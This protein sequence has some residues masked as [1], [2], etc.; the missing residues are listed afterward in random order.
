VAEAFLWGAA[1]SSALLAGA[2]VAYAFRPGPRLNAVVLALG[3]GLLLGAVSL[4]LVEDAIEEGDLL[5]VAL[6]LML[7]AV[8][9]VAGDWVLD[10]RGAAGRKDPR[11]AQAEGS[12][13]GIVLGSVLD[14]IPESLVLGLTVLQGGVGLPLL[15]GVALSNFPEGMASSSGLRAAGWRRRTVLTMWA[16]VAVISACAALAGYVLLEGA[17]GNV[18]AGVNAFAAGALLAMIADTMLP[19]AYEEERSLTGLFVA[20]GFALSVGLDAL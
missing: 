10:R 19:E 4:S 15:M 3:A 16:G 12:A 18:V 6:A 7:G 13:E 8:T 5:T 17:S 14:G 2:A 11:G 1:A 20:L 9:F